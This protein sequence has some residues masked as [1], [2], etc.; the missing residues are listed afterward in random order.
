[1]KRHA[2]KHLFCSFIALILTTAAFAQND[3]GAQWKP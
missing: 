1:M 2:M 3:G